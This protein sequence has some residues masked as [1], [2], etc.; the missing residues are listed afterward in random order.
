M[1]S[2]PGQR[3]M[4]WSLSPWQ[5]LVITGLLTYTIHRFFFKKTHN[6]PRV[7]YWIPYIGSAIPFGTN[8]TAFVNN[9]VKKYGGYFSVYLAGQESIFIVDP[10]LFAAV[11]TNKSLSMRPLIKSVEMAMGIPEKQAEEEVSPES[12]EMYHRLFKLL[13]KSDSLEVL[14]QRTEKELLRIMKRLKE[15][16]SLSG[17]SFYRLVQEVTFE[18]SV[19]SLFGT[20]FY[21]KE[22]LDE[23]LLFD[24]FFPLFMAQVPEW[25]NQ[26]GVRVRDRIADD[27]RRYFAFGDADDGSEYFHER[28]K[29]FLQVYGQDDP[30]LGRAQVGFMWAVV[31]NTIPAI[32]WLLLHLYRNLEALK[33]IRDELTSKLPFEGLDVEKEPWSRQQLEDCVLLDS[34]IRETL[35]LVSG[36]LSI[37]IALEDTFLEFP[38]LNQKIFL[39]KGQRIMCFPAW[40]QANHQYF[41]RADEFFYDR[42]V[43]TKDTTMVFGMAPDLCPGRF[44][45]FN[46]IKIITAL[47]LRCTVFELSDEP[48]GL[49]YSRAGLGIYPPTQD[50]TANLDFI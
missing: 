46:E 25:L 13:M 5:G 22:K 27:L 38:K 45:A 18:A 50:V 32:F 48:V 14:T 34:A 7:P 11:R 12:V 26:K 9:C 1:K 31:A 36:S 16:E 49:D 6:A 19:I 37:R 20:N 3:D 4:V 10:S 17:V 2:H 24:Q 42:F 44:W 39:P 35:R 23:F 15:Q 29:H 30:N 41:E 21:S 33:A 47:F 40:N 8:P 43:K 28:R